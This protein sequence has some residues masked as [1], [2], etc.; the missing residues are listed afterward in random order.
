VTSDVLKDKNVVKKLFSDSVLYGIAIIA[1][2]LASIVLLPIYTHYLSP[3]GY[4]VI[5]L[6]SMLVD[7]AAIFFG[8]RIGQSFLRFYGLSAIAAEKN[9][10]FSTSFGM[11][12]ATHLVG[13]SLLVLLCYPVSRALF[14]SEEYTNVLFIYSFTLF[15]GGVIEIP[16]AFLRANGRAGSVLLFSLLKLTLQVSLNLYLLVVLE[17]GVMGAAIAS[18][19]AQALVALIITL[20]CFYN[21]RFVFSKDIGKQLIGFSLPI[22][23]AAVSMFFITYGDR[24]YIRTYLSLADVGIYALAYKFGFIL[25]SL[26][27]QPFQSM[28][29]AQRY[30]I[31]KNKELHHLFAKVFNF[32][33]IVLIYIAFGI[34]VWIEPFLSIM[35]SDE[36]AS[37]ANYVPYIMLGYVFLAWSGFCNLGIFTSGKT[38]SFG[39]ISMTT[40]VFCM[41]GYWICIPRYGLY[42]AA[43][44]TALAFLLR[45]A[46]IHTIA[47]RH[48]DMGLSWYT[49]VMALCFAV[50]LIVVKE[51]PYIKGINIWASG[52]SLCLLFPVSMV[53]F[54]VVKISDL[55]TFYTTFIKKGE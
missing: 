30:N 36:F 48:F 1:R 4:G 5:E 6:L 43:M 35:S 12:S 53:V 40:A 44:V 11:V 47:K 26:A 41:L 54:R 50:A 34:V 45:L 22:I 51:L 52:I 16:M 15:F 27:W 20:F 38:K 32:I 13:A 9:A 8:A 25:F 7:F 46:A 17:K 14:G 23:L 19:T 2:S 37:A 39:I 28:W 42:G 24:F 18:V 33:S 31:F 49:P 3:E 21:I 29:D 10:I 55:V